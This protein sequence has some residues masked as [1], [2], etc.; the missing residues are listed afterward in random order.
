VSG[1]VTIE[2]SGGEVEG[3]TVSGRFTVHGGP[4]DRVKLES[5][6]GDTEFEGSWP[7]CAGGREQSHRL[8]RL[9]TG[10]RGRGRVR[11]LHLLGRDSQRVRRAPH[12]VDSTARARSTAATVGGGG[13]RIAIESFSG[14]VR[15]RKPL[16]R[17]A[18]RNSVR[19]SSELTLP[20]S[21]TAS[22]SSRQLCITYY[23]TSVV[24]VRC[25]MRPG[26]NLG[27]GGGRL[28]VTRSL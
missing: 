28:I 27:R 9:R 11:C 12:R 6:S 17:G 5:V 25:A 23:V 15:L 18:G 14:S 26:R 10:R 1:S 16:T 7:G 3:S 24:V 20:A 19:N 4:F 2:S 8:G 22:G 21:R 13:P